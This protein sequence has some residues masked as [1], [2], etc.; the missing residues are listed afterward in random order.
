MTIKAKYLVGG[1]LIVF[2]AL[3]LLG[4]HTGAKR[5]KSALNASEKA[6]NDS[7][8]FLTIEL[9]K[10]TNY[11]SK[12]E[13]ELVSQ[14]ELIKRGELE[15]E[16][17][18]KLNIRTANEVTKLNLQ[19]DTLLTDVDHNGKIIGILTTQLDSVTWESNATLPDAILLPF[20]FKK[21]DEWTDIRGAFNNEGKLDMSVR[22]SVKIDVLTGI[23]KNKTPFALLKTDNP[24][25]KP[26]ILSS[27]KTD[28]QKPRRIGIGGQLGY[29]FILGDPV[30]T[31]P[32]IGVG[33]SYN[34]INL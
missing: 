29:G 9:S 6:K 21:T 10:K 30:K 2:L 33:I 20:E 24:Y 25:I 13:Q 8:T 27:Y 19:I 17:L 26:L 14:K 31:A 32:Y 22:M 4:W 23:D 7:I 15:R 5:T 34:I 16:A 12:V 11:I 28:T 1:I 18:R 3:F